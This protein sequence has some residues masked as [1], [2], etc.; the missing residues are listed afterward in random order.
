M[1]I[2][3]P[4]MKVCILDPASRL[5]RGCG[6]TLEE[7]GRW[8]VMTDAE[9]RRVMAELPQRLAGFVGAAGGAAGS[10]RG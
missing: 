1:A 4:C 7:I 6:R 3:T 5:C 9:R 2:D 10:A 8:T